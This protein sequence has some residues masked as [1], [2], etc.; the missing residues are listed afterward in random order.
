[1]LSFSSSNGLLDPWHG[2]GVL[3]SYPLQNITSIIIANGA[4][5]LDLRASNPA[6]P[7]DVVLARKAELSIIKQWISDYRQTDRQQSKN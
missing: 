6:D 1:M 2:G 7:A 4:H 5:H 3:Q